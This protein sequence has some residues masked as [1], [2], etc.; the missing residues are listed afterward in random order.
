[1]KCLWGG[2]NARFHYTYSTFY[3]LTCVQTQLSCRPYLQSLKFAF[4]RSQP[5]H[6]KWR[7]HVSS[8]AV[9]VRNVYKW[10]A[11][12]AETDTFSVRIAL[13][14]CIPH[15]RIWFKLRYSFALSEKVYLR[16]PSRQP[17]FFYSHEHSL[18]MRLRGYQ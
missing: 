5:L 13:S 3:N 16:N 9:C 17:L 1:M 11:I 4:I 2:I 6:A 15:T 7:T 10:D 14:D 18:K 12:P 8:P